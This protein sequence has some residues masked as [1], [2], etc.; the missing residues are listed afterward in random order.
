MELLSSLSPDR[1]GEG[2]GVFT[3]ESQALF[4][5][6]ITFIHKEKLHHIKH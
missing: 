2:G 1:E 3:P 6:Y 4:I 5:L